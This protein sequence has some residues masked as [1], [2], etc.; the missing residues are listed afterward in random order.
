MVT[1]KPFA[2]ISEHSEFRDEAEVL[3]MLVASIFRLR[4]IN[5]NDADQIWIIRITLCSDENHDLKQVLIYMKQQI[6]NGEPNLGTLGK[7]LWEMGKLDLAGKYFH[8]LLKE[9]PSNNPLLYNLYKDL[10]KIA[11]QAGNYDMSVQWHQKSLALKIKNQLTTISK[12]IERKF[13]FFKQVTYI[14]MNM[15]LPEKNCKNSERRTTFED[16]IKSIKKNHVF[17]LSRNYV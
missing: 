14:N 13:V 9:L 15:L 1:T 2:D 12:F 10:A 8:R 17:C 4:C 16:I 6:G 7:V 11:S 5:H 3:F